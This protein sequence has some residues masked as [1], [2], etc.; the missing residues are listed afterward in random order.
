MEGLNIQR[1]EFE[2]LDGNRSLPSSFLT[3]LLRL[4]VS[5]TH[6][7]KAFPWGLHS[8]RFRC[9]HPPPACAVGGHCLHEVKVAPMSPASPR[10]C[11]TAPFRV[12]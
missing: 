6:R 11:L 10:L 12:P 4:Q 9:P 2:D 1:V 7:A 3:V 8:P 5:G